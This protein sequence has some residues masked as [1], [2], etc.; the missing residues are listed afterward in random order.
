MNNIVVHAGLSTLLELEFV[1][2]Q[3]KSFLKR[4]ITSRRSTLFY[5]TSFEVGSIQQQ[6]QRQ[7]K[8][9]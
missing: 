2:E 4:A 7:Q 9:R 1:M 8:Q 5:F 3:V 6:Q